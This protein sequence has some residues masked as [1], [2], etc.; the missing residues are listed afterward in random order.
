MLTLPNLLTLSRIVTVPVLVALLWWPTWQ[1]GYAL[2]FA[3]Y[4]LMG[5][6]DYFDGYLARAQGAVSRLGVFLDPIAD[7]L[8]RR[9]MSRLLATI[10]ILVGFLLV[11]ILALLIVVPI[12]GNQV[13]GFLERLPDLVRRL[14]SLVTSLD[15]DWLNRLTGGDTAG[16]PLPWGRASRRRAPDA[17]RRSVPLAR[18]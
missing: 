3:V 6:T 13:A 14:Q 9:G 16:I 10:V 18:W 2:A 17:R 15:L 4:C 8:E 11:F 7:F 5:V 1:T 12:L